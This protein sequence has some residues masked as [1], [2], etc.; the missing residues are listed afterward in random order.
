[1]LE[2]PGTNALAYPV[3]CSSTV[4]FCPSSIEIVRCFTRYRDKRTSL[5]SRSE[6][7]EKS[8]PKFSTRLGSNKRE[9]E[10]ED[11][12]H[13]AFKF[14]MLKASLDYDSGFVG[15]APVPPKPAGFRRKKK[16]SSGSAD[17]SDEVSGRTSSMS[18]L[19][20]SASTHAM[21]VKK[22]RCQSH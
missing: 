17:R 15:A 2:W 8:F 21:S 10:E 16:S 22:S 1:M 4:F 13:E 9:P 7:V 6:K 19:S 11:K 5:S 14:S 20:H 12:N 18:H 3:V